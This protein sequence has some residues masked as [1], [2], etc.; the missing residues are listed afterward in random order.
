MRYILILL[1]AILYNGEVIGQAPILDSS[2]TYTVGNSFAF[3]RPIQPNAY[4]SIIDQVG[5]NQVWD[6]SGV[7]YLANTDFI[8]N[9]TMP[10]DTTNFLPSPSCNIVSSENKDH[11]Y[12]RRKQIKK[13][14][15]ELYHYGDHLKDIFFTRGYK[16]NIFPW[17]FGDSKV[18]YVTLVSHLSNDTIVNIVGNDTS[19]FDGYGTLITADEVYENVMRIKTKMDLTIVKDYFYPNTQSG[20]RIISKGTLEFITFYK[21]GFGQPILRVHVENNVPILGQFFDQGL[22]RKF[23]LAIDQY[24][25]EKEQML[26]IKPNPAQ[27]K[28]S[29]ALLKGKEAI[30]NIE[31]YDVAGRLMDQYA[32]LNMMNAELNVNNLPNGIYFINVYN[33]SIKTTQKLVIQR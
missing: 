6:V 28:V 14:A 13:T 11:Q 4:E 8:V 7:S 26:S 2:A 10:M 20:E 29:I 3:D 23:R 22:Y 1:V 18:E 30:K 9:S 33:Q 15:T 21:N 32:N 19:I 12:W 27:N 25:S 17:H 16:E 24:S 5:T 31:I